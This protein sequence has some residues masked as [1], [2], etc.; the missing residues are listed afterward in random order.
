MKVLTKLLIN[1]DFCL[2]KI[3]DFLLLRYRHIMK[4]SKA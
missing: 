2:R 4:Q 1:K 3:V